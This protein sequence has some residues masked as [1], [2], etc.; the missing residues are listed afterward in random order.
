M[1]SDE[2][3]A[4]S[5]FAKKFWPDGEV[6][7][8]WSRFKAWDANPIMIA[9]LDGAI[10]GFHGCLFQTNSYINSL[11]IATAPE[12]RGMGVGGDL[13]HFMLACPKRTVQTRLKF[14]CALNSPGNAFW[15]GF[16]AVPYARSANEYFYDMFIGDARDIFQVKE[17]WRYQHLAPP[18]PPQQ[19][20]RARQ[21]GATLLTE[22]L[23]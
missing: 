16:G 7:Y 4:V 22:R 5:D 12:A 3:N 2:R 15:H 10:A 8:I 1:R 17:L 11:Y 9:E 18:V 21:K 23:F 6:A 20:L 13:F 14:K 19:V